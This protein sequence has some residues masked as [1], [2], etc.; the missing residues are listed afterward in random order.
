MFGEDEAVRNFKRQMKTAGCDMTVVKT[1]QKQLKWIRKQKKSI[2]GGY[3]VARESLVR[4]D[5]I[6]RRMEQMLTEKGFWTKERMR[7]IKSLRKELKKLSDSFHN[8]FLVSKDDKD[9]H[10][11]Y[12]SILRL[13]DSFDGKNDNRILLLSEVEN[14][15]GRL[16]ENLEKEQPDPV[17]LTY[18]Y[19]K[20]TDAELSELP[21]QGKLVRIT[22]VYEEEF[23]QPLLDE[24]ETHQVMSEEEF[25]QKMDFILSRV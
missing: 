6:V 23:L 17:R 16:A 2:Y 19:C 25:Q 13:A 7:E 22:N 14:L 8:E 21:A 5:T 1:W 11:T 20:H 3:T 18:F 9:F 24:S 15:L 10:L 12:Q 4:V